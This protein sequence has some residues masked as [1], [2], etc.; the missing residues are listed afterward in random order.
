MWFYC[1]FTLNKE[2][3]YLLLIDHFLGKND[4]LNEDYWFYL[5]I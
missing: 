5:V 1:H 3:F 2:E 4:N